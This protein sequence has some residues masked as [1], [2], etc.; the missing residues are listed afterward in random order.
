M[1]V[2]T[3]EENKERRKRDEKRRIHHHIY[4]EQTGGDMQEAVK[5]A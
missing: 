5:T 2:E 1:H 3:R 4:A